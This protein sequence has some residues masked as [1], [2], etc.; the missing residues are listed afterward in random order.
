MLEYT[1]R[2]R[3]LY[4]FSGDQHLFMGGA[5]IIDQEHH[6]LDLCPEVIH[7]DGNMNTNDEKYPLFTVTGKD[8]L[9]NFFTFIRAF[10]QNTKV[11]AFQWVFQVVFP[12]FILRKTLWR[13]N[14]IISDGNSSEYTQSDSDIKEVM[15]YVL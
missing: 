13:I 11:W 8:R 4:Q 10:L 15:P 14:I 7:I 2:H 1:K 5:W 9:G 12:S 3:Y 6:Q